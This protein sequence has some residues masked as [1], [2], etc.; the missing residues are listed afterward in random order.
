MACKNSCTVNVVKIIAALLNKWSAPCLGPH[1]HRHEAGHPT[2]VY[3]LQRMVRDLDFGIEV[4]GMPI[5]RE[6]DG[7]AMSR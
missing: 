7:L 3:W 2:P 5:M 4:V 6:D 1:A